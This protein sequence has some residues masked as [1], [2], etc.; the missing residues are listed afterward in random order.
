MVHEAHMG[1]RGAPPVLAT[2]AG[3]CV[4]QTIPKEQAAS[5]KLTQRIREGPSKVEFFTAR[6]RAPE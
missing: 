3:S 5:S 2:W 4:K 6:V 1:T